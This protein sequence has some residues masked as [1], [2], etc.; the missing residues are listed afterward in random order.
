M[1][2]CRPAPFLTFQNLR[3]LCIEVLKIQKRGIGLCV[4]AE[5]EK[6]GN[7]AVLRPVLLT[8]FGVMTQAIGWSRTRGESAQQELNGMTAELVEV[9]MSF[10]VSYA[11]ANA[12]SGTTASPAPPRPGA[13]HHLRD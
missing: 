9:D 1:P 5:W 8:L 13:N 2:P 3:N 10:I 4:L 11:T 7:F 12:S 6:A